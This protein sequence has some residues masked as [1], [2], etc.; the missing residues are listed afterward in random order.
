LVL[1]V[2]RFLLRF[3]TDAGSHILRALFR[4]L[5]SSAMDLRFTSMLAVIFCMIAEKHPAG[6]WPGLALTVSAA[7]F[8]LTLFNI[9]YFLLASYFI[10]KVQDAGNAAIPREGTRR[11]IDDWA[12]G[13]QLNVGFLGLIFLTISYASLCYAYYMCCVA[14][15]LPEYQWVVTAG[16]AGEIAEQDSPSPEN[17]APEQ[18]TAQ[19]SEPVAE[20]TPGTFGYSQFFSHTGQVLE[21]SLPFLIR[22]QLTIHP[23][24]LKASDKALGLQVVETVFSYAAWGAFAALLSAI[25]LPRRIFRAL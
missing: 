22:K 9:G 1:A 15:G 6:Y 25:L 17:T 13:V 16:V 12:L 5:F 10:R 4:L 2:L 11:D 19:P 7:A 8:V 20:Q 24:T 14:F 21:R 3:V 23:L 18:T